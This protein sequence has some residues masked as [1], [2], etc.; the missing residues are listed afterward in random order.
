MSRKKTLKNTKPF[1]FTI[2]KEIVGRN[3]E[4]NKKTIPFK[5]QFLHY[6]RF[7]KG[8]LSNVADNVADGIHKTTCKY[9]LDN[10]KCKTHGIKYKDCCRE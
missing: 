5:F 10:K 6:I 7:V 1:Y 8:S 9:G 3:G 2:T 4:E